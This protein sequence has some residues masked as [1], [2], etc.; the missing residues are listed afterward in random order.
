[1]DER[2]TVLSSSRLN[3]KAGS[4]VLRDLR[5]WHRGV[6]NNSDG[7]RS[8]LA[9]VYKRHF[10]GWAHESLRVPQSTWD[11]WPADVR[12]IFANAPRDAD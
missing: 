7:Q 6:P 8:M 4:I 12:S 3:V 11:S 10:L 1:M 2:T 9:I 5:V